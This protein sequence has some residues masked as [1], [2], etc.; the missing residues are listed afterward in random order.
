MDRAGGDF[1]Q[2]WAGALE[3]L[4]VSRLR[5][6]RFHYEVLVRASDGRPRR[7]RVFADDSAATRVYVIGALSWVDSFETDVIA[8]VFGR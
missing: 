6:Q 5:P 4:E 1:E 8:G 3:L 2:A 7:I